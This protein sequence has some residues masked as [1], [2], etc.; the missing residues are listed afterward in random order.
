M[1]ATFQRCGG[2]APRWV[3][4]RVASS[5]RRPRSLRAGERGGVA[6]E[7]LERLVVL[8]VIGAPH[9]TVTV[10]EQELLGVHD[11]LLAL[12]RRGGQFQPGGG[13]EHRVL[14]AG[15]EVPP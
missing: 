12:C 3:G 10:D 7:L 15:Q 1:P 14:R 2:R 9:P 11:G 5:E 4:S 6:A 8:T 13:G